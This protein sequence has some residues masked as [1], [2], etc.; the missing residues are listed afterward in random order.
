M[1]LIPITPTVLISFKE[2]IPTMMVESTIGTTMN[3][4]K[5][6]KIVPKGFM[7]S[8]AKGTQSVAMQIKPAIIPRTRPIKI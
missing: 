7:Y 5:F 2:M 4:I 1:V 3:L 6:K 8:F